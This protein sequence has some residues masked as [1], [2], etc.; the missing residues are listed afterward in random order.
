MAK[1]ALVLVN[2]ASWFNA[3]KDGGSLPDIGKVMGQIKNK[4]DPERVVFMADFTQQHIQD[5]VPQIQKFT[6][7]IINT[8]DMKRDENP[9]LFCMMEEL[10]YYIGAM[11]AEEKPNHAVIVI[12]GDW[13]LAAPLTFVNDDAGVEVLVMCPAGRLSVELREAVPSLE[14]EASRPENK[15]G[16]EVVRDEILSSLKYTE[17]KGLRATFKRTATIVAEKTNSEIIYV[18]KIL[19]DMISGGEV[20]KYTETGPGGQESKLIR[21]NWDQVKKDE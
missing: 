10:L 21:A 20:S 7:I 18:E 5:T 17:D 9:I 4:Y 14:F 2:Y 6:D 19:T 3:S 13:R 15:L 11:P 8:K 1:K 16:A 12:A